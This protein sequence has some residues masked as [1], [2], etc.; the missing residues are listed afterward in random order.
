MLTAAWLTTGQRI[1]PIGLDLGYRS[2]KMV[3]LAVRDGKVQVLATARATVDE[4][5]G[6]AQREKSIVR[7]IRQLLAA[8]R[9]QGQHVISA[10]PMDKI[11]ITSVRLPETETDQ[12]DKILRR[13]AVERFKLDPARGVV[14]YILAGSVRQ[15]DEAKN[16]YILFAVENGAVESHIRL[17]E[18]AGLVPT[19]IDAPP[20]ALFRTFERTMRRQADR[21]K[22]IIFIDVGHRYTTVVFGRGGEICFVKQIALGMGQFNDEV[23]SALGVAVSEAEAFRLRL[24]QEEAI[25]A[26]T[27]RPV[28]DALNL[29]SEQLAGEIS[30]CL[31]Y[32]T[33]TFRG[34][35]VERAILA[36]GGAYEPVLRDVLRRHLSVEV[37]VAEPFRGFEVHPDRLE[38]GAADLA[39]AV[40][41]SLK[42]CDSPAAVEAESVMELL[43]EPAGELV[44]EGL[45]L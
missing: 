18:D 42:G 5:G 27:R 44:G 39:L 38:S 1:G 7:A 26:V 8:G 6:D 36:G 35:R 43:A 13:E 14:N 25:D 2:L 19:A 20:C 12:A 28:I 22:T 41:L 40:G 32:Y 21:E 33:V 17:L 24:Q 10:L 16:E 31:R 29:M 3:Q 4:A 9:F 45:A 37:E 34:K 30:L 11:R 23:A 15:G